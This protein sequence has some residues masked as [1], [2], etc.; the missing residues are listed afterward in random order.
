MADKKKVESMGAGI[1]TKTNK[2]GQVVGY[3]FRCCVGRDEQY[4]QIWRTTTISHDDPRLEGLTPKKLKDELSSI[5]H[6]WDKEQKAEYEKN[7]SKTDKAKITFKEFVSDHWMPDHVIPGHTPSSIQFFQYTSEMAIEYF[8]DKKKLKDIDTEA[9]KRYLNFLNTE[10]RAK[11]NVIKEI[12]FTIANNEDSHAVLTW[13]AQKDALSYQIFRKSNRSKEFIK[14]ASTDGLTFT[15]SQM[16]NCSYQVKAWFIEPGDEH[17]SPTSVKHFFGSLRNVLRYAKRMKYITSDPTED[18]APSEKPHREKKGIDF[19]RPNEAARFLQC[20]ESEDLYWR[21]LLNVLLISGLRRGEAVALQWQ[22]LDS[23]KLELSIVRNVTLDKNSENGLSIGKTKTGESRIVP[24]SDRMEKMLTK[25]KTEREYQLSEKDENGK[26]ITAVTLPGTSYIFCGP[27]PFRPIR[28]DSVTTK[29]R[30]FVEKNNLP[31]VS[32]H[33]LRHSAAALALEAGTDLKSIQEL[34]GHA[35]AE[36]TMRYYAGVTEEA[37]RRSI[38][39][40]ENLLF[41]KAGNQK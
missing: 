10:A 39:G 38:E 30:R 25:L 21:C 12:P 2:D 36:T 8:G 6:E 14:I 32:P 9:V 18:L 13:E 23:K 3:K 5:K 16:K 11:V 7:H 15:D 26:I 17:F 20:L 37:K 19:L 33:D 35:D 4:K 22:D 31:N 27:D 40:T 1:E 34:L 41:P 28:P 24:I 29:V